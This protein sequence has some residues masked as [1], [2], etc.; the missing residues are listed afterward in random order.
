MI[1]TQQVTEIYPQTPLT[2]HGSCFSPD[3][4]NNTLMTQT[5]KPVI[6]IETIGELQC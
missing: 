6:T 2:W 4:S 5:L 1:A 3:M